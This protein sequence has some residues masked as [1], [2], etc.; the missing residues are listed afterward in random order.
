MDSIYKNPVIVLTRKI[1]VPNQNADI[2]YPVVTGMQDLAVQQKINSD[3][4]SLV[5]R[6]ISLQVNQLISQGYN[7]LVLSITGW[8]E[9]K[10]NERGVLSLTIGNYT[11]ANPAAH[12][13]TI[14]KSLT[15]DTGTGKN[16]LLSE[17]FKV[18]SNYVKALSDIIRVQIKERDIQL[19]NGFSG[20]KPEQ[21]YYISDKVLVIYFQ[22]YEITA[23]YYGLP[24][25]PVSVYQIQDIIREG[26]PLDKVAMGD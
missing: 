5:N 22:Q 10:T 12:G 7:K 20:I 4:V 19:L 6:L 15:F 11:I 14:I 24:M 1:S 17:Q 9:I 8:Y 18:G 23:G 26:S 21:D 25:F 2:S 13:L 16:Y 3:I